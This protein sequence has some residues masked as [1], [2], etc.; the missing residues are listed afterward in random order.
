MIP[1][2]EAP[3]PG[4]T[5]PTET[6]A[7]LMAFAVSISDALIDSNLVD[8]Q[9]L[10]KKLSLARLGLEGQKLPIAAGILG[11]IA[12]ALQDPAA[13][14]ARKNFADAVLIPAKGMKQ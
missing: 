12:A 13:V 4:T 6:D 2:S 3:A 9:A 10:V 1:M 11:T 5:S 8:R 7:A 14:A